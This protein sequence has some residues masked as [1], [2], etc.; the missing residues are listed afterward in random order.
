MSKQPATKKEKTKHNKKALTPTVERKKRFPDDDNEDDSDEVYHPTKSPYSKESEE[1]DSE[2]ESEDEKKE[3]KKIVKEKKVKKKTKAK[4]EKKVKEKDKNAPKRPKA[5]HFLAL[6]EFKEKNKEKHKGLKG[7]EILKLFHEEWKKV[8]PE[9]KKKFED[10]HLDQIKIYEEQKKKYSEQYSKDHPENDSDSDSDSDKKK[11]K[12]N[13]NLPKRPNSAYILYSNKI[14]AE[15]K[16]EIEKEFYSE[17]GTDEEKK[18]EKSKKSKMVFGEI[19]KA[20]G[21]KWKALPEDKRKPFQDEAM[22]LKE[23]YEK[24]CSE[25]GIKLKKKK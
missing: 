16:A 15:V 6:D 10:I 1:T 19:T 3:K 7:A 23:E 4:K 21:K 11:R 2:S 8:K 20:I 24:K 12:K 22:K 5:I 18:E 14:R 25:N 9:E 17:K 13:P